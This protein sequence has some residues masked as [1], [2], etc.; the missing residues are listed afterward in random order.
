MFGVW[1]FSE[2]HLE[3]IENLHFRY[4]RFILKL[5]N[6]TPKPKLYGETGYMPIKVVIITRIIC[7][8]AKLRGMEG[9]SKQ[10]DIASEQLYIDL[11][12]LQM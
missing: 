8:L 11:E 12:S 1:G 6:S 9:N 7:Y 3:M 10:M 4:V 5:N 2:T